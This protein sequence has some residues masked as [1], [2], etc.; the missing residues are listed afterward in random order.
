MK[1]LPSVPNFPQAP[2]VL[3][4]GEAQGEPRSIFTK[5]RAIGW[6][7]LTPSNISPLL[8]SLDLKDIQQS[9]KSLWEM[10]IQD[11]FK[12]L[13]EGKEIS[14]GAGSL[15]HTDPSHSVSGGVG[16]VWL[17]GPYN[18]WKDSIK[19]SRAPQRFVKWWHCWV[20]CDLCPLGAE[21]VLSAVSA[22]P[23]PEY[24]GRGGHSQAHTFTQ[25]CSYSIK[26]NS[27]D[28]KCYDSELAH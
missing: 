21:S 24:P 16:T 13:A 12:N 19:S 20:I 22:G 1:I 3:Y 14:D 28:T 18:S 5:I 25:R 10:A 7:A 11:H 17:K 9:Q 6:H 8:F 4:P 27:K 23:H 15:G 26:Y 2:W